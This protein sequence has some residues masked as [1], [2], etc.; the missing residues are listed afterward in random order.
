MDELS[1]S[2]SIQAARVPYRNRWKSRRS[3]PDASRTVRRGGRE[4]AATVGPSHHARSIGMSEQASS[5]TYNTTPSPS[6]HPRPLPLTLM[7]N[8]AVTRPHVVSGLELD[9][10][11]VRH[12]LAP[13]TITLQVYEQ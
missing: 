11:S 2:S 6:L 12:V 9:C 3:G 7:Q 13:P 8:C 1:R 4:E 5:I 10:F